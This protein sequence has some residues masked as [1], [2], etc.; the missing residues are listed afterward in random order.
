[1]TS[2][3]NC[4][5]CDLEGFTLTICRTCKTPLIISREHRSYFAPEEMETL[6]KMSP[7]E[8]IRW[9]MKGLPM[10]AHYHLEEK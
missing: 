7:S 3:H 6:T 10:H 9:E 4:D 8:K 1:M 2:A 5:L